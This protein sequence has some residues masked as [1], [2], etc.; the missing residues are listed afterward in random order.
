MADNPWLPAVVL[1]AAPHL[2]PMP[3]LPLPG[4]PGPFAFA[5]PARIRRVLGE[6]GFANISATPFDPVVRLPGPAVAHA[7]LLIALGPAGGVY[8]RAAAPA[9]AAARAGVTTQ[10]SRFTTPD[11]GLALPSGLWL[12]EARAS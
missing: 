4:E 6:A 2:D 8:D 1:G 7:E 3:P 11:G 12:I 10:L 9:Q 5:D